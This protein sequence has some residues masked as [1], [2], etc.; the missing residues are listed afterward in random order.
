M[1]FSKRA[2]DR[3]QYTT[4][5]YEFRHIQIALLFVIILYATIWLRF[6]AYA[7]FFMTHS[8]APPTKLFPTFSL[9]VIITQDIILVF[10]FMFFRS[11][12]SESER[13]KNRVIDNGVTPFGKTI[14][15]EMNRLGKDFPSFRM[16]R[17]CPTFSLV[18]CY[19]EEE[20]TKWV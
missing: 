7:E 14:I 20:L 18:T 12:S 3:T 15:K 1:L 16:S 10:I 6:F 8:V 4:K 19:F 11:E 9:Y 5:A 13:S 2:D 17:P